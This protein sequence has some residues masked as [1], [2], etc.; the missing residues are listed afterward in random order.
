MTSTARSYTCILQCQDKC[1][2]LSK[3]AL[4]PQI[5]KIDISYDANEFEYQILTQIDEA[6]K[7][8]MSF[9]IYFDS[10]LGPIYFVS[11]NPFF[12]LIFQFPCDNQYSPSQL[13]Y[14]CKK[15]VFGLVDQLSTPNKKDKSV[16]LI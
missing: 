13:Y 9:R 1:Q 16:K 8:K 15:T 4:S 14:S 11:K 2:D 10:G 7:T 6:K 3:Q 12:V 5:Q